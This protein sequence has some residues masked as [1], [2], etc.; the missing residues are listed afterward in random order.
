MRFV[1]ETGGSW[2]EQLRSAEAEIEQQR[3][4]WEA[5]RLAAL[6][7]EEEDAKRAEEEENQLLTYSGA[8]AR[9]Q[10]NNKSKKP[11]N[12][13]L[14]RN[15]RRLTNA[16]RRTVKSNQLTSGDIAVATR[17]SQSNRRSQPSANV[18]P[19][20]RKI[21]DTIATKN[22]TSVRTI[23]K[24]LCRQTNNSRSETTDNDN[25]VSSDGGNASSNESKKGTSSSSNSFVDSDEDSLDVCSL[26]VMYDEQQS[27]SNSNQAPS[28]SGIDNEK[29][30]N[31]SDNSEN[32]DESDNE[33]NGKQCNNKQMSGDNRRV[34]SATNR[35]DINS[36]RTRSR[37][38]VKLNLW[39]LDDSPILPSFGGRSKRNQNKS[40]NS[41][42]LNDKS[43]SENVVQLKTARSRSNSTSRKSNGNDESRR[44]RSKSQSLER[45]AI[46]ATVDRSR[47]Q[48]FS[49][50][51][52]G[53]ATDGLK[54]NLIE[55]LVVATNRIESNCHQNHKLTTAD[56]RN[57][58]N[59]VMKL[60]QIK[61]GLDGSRPLK[62][63]RPSTVK[64]V[65]PSAKNGRSSSTLDSWLSKS[66]KIVL[67]KDD[68]AIAK[69]LTEMAGRTRRASTLKVHSENGP[70]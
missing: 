36:P 33:M 18:S 32:S 37:G 58:I 17:R 59:T 25:D 53:T 21:D 6:R 31:S 10:V 65:T 30:D 5:N 56:R 24:R 11:V 45:S 27:E 20:K 22:Q 13:S 23:P 60:A 35:V 19:R 2:T 69:H 15:K 41:N 51:V 50:D 8:D 68:D 62:A 14:G 55:D 66:P 63:K 46:N 3:Q 64:K 29:S 70:S 44:S 42:E 48:S 43:G 1:E 57:T 34:S 54:S 28:S 4:E 38:T 39:A 26:D 40:F 67:N 12:R 49:N 52:D 61:D 7:K 47:S 9:N 16:R